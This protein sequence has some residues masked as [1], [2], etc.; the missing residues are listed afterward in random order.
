MTAGFPTAPVGNTP[1]AIN[2]TV[3]ESAFP[4]VRSDDAVTMMTAG[5]LSPT[6]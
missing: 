5:A 4:A 2:E 1:V 3:I 6:L